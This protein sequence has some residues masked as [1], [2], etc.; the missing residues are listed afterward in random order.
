MYPIN[1]FSGL[2]GLSP[3]EVSWKTVIKFEDPNV[4][5]FSIDFFVHLSF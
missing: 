5:V 4:T 1:Q 2:R 3:N